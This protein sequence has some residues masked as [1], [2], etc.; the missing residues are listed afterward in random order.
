MFKRKFVL[1]VQVMNNLALPDADLQNK[2]QDPTVYDSIERKNQRGQL[3][4]EYYIESPAGGIASSVTCYSGR[5]YACF[6]TAPL[7]AFLKN[8]DVR[9]NATVGFSRFFFFSFFK[10]NL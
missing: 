1:L 2:L 5:L 6:A 4:Y 9:L 8:K 10:T 7:P 3:Y